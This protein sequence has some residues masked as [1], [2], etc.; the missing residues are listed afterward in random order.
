MGRLQKT[1]NELKAQLA[2]IS[3][4]LLAAQEQARLAWAAYDDLFEAVST[5]DEDH[6][7][8]EEMAHHIR[9]EV[10]DDM[11]ADGLRTVNELTDRLDEVTR[12]SDRE[13]VAAFVRLID[14]DE[15][16]SDDETLQLIEVIKWLVSV[17]S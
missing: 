16:L 2:E 1:T 13:A 14:S 17:R 8:V 3:E 15:Q 6:P 5:V 10:W 12:F 11:R 7:L 9:T 4:Q